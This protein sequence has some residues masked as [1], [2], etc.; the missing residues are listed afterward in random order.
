MSEK[1]ANDVKVKQDE[2]LTVRKEVVRNLTAEELSAVHG[3]Q[4]PTGDPTIDPTN[5]HG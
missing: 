2:Q 1:E 3:G 4:P 5:G